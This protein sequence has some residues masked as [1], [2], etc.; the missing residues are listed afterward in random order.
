MTTNIEQSLITQNTGS[1]IIY[2]F[3][4]LG[5]KPTIE[6]WIREAEII[7]NNNALIN[8]T[9]LD[10]LSTPNVTAT[11]NSSTYVYSLYSLYCH[12][13]PARHDTCYGYLEILLPNTYNFVKVTFNQYSHLE[14]S[15]DTTIKLIENKTEKLNSKKK[16]ST[17]EPK[18]VNGTNCYSDGTIFKC[19]YEQE[20]SIPNTILRI[21]EYYNTIGYN[22]KIELSN[23]PINCIGGPT[24]S[25]TSYSTWTN[26]SNPCPN[27]NDYNSIDT[28]FNNITQSRTR[29]YIKTKNQLNGG[30]CNQEADI[31]TKDTRTISCPRNCLGGPVSSD[32]S[33]SVWSNWSDP[34][35]NVN[36][37]NSIDASFN[38]ITQSRTRTYIKTK[39]QLNGGLCNQEEDI[40]TK[41]T[42]TISCPRNCSW[43]ISPWSQCIANCNGINPTSQGIKTR[44]VTKISYAINGGICNTPSNSEPCIKT[45]CVVKSYNTIANDVCTGD[46]IICKFTTIGKHIFIVEQDSFY[47]ILLVGGGGGGGAGFGS[48]GGGGDVIEKLNHRLNKGEYTITI[49]YGGNG[50][51]YTYI[52]PNQIYTSGSNGS[53]SS[54]TSNVTGFIPLYAAGGG[55][56]LTLE[57]K[58]PNITPTEG[59][60]ETNNYSSGGGG[61]GSL[62]ERGGSGNGV[63]GNG[64]GDGSGT[65]PS[66]AGGGGG[67]I[68]SGISWRGQRFAIN[69]GT[70]QIS[71]ITGSPIGYGG[72]GGGGEL[73]RTGIDGGGNGGGNGTA[74]DTNKG[75][76]GGGGGDRSSGGAG[77]SGIVIIKP[78][79]TNCIW[80]AKCIAT[81]DGIS[82]SS[83]GNITFIK[84]IEA[85]N[86][87]ICNAHPNS[88][89][90]TKT[91]CA[92]DC[93]G[94][95]SDWID[96]S[97]NPVCPSRT[98][99]SISDNSFNIIKNRTRRFDISYNELNGG[100]CSQRD[101]STNTS[102]TY[103]LNCPRDCSG[104]YSDWVDTSNNPVC[105]SST[106]YS[107][108]ENS[109]N[110]I[111]NRTRTFNIYYNALNG[112]TCPQTNILN[113]TGIYNFKCA[114][115]CS[116][117]YSDWVDT[118]NNQDC[119]SS[120]NYSISDNSF[121]IIRNRTRRFDILYNELNG[122]ICSQRDIS[123]NTSGTYDLNCPRD[124]LG[125]PVSSDTSYTGWSNWSNPCPNAN[126]Y[127]APDTSFNIIQSRKRTYIKTKNQLN[128]GSCKQ[129]EDI[130][131]KDT[132][133]I[134]CLRNCGGGPTTSDTSYTEWSNWSNPCPNANDYNAPDTSFNI[135]QSRTRTYIKIK[136]QLN[137]G[138]CNQEEDIYTKDKRTITC[139]RDCSG[140]WTDWGD[141]NAN[142]N[143][144]YRTYTIIK[145]HKNNGVP[146]P[147]QL[148]ES[149]KCETKNILS[150]IVNFFKLIL[151]FIL[152]LFKK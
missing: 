146:C 95:Y 98:N 1:T 8:G 23:I 135:T 69:G 147:S 108:S 62:Y 32:A 38:N 18:G 17:I 75:G 41:D 45:N 131:T 20:Y 101:I 3:G 4:L 56:G 76:G 35:P 49:G 124:C 10:I 33:Y 150:V 137:G 31:Y 125:G 86:G 112:G 52:H 128:G 138:S 22:I 27:V 114:R 24:T 140:N 127:N 113:T 77:G 89:P 84:T 151:S 53:T 132:R 149:K 115:D 72:G 68:G 26:W 37:Y 122:G 96:T 83:I 60:I 54:I 79:P 133:T 88:T 152:N 129:E 34:C 116:G 90:C 55:G 93:S 70:G 80:E 63:S 81:C 13:I 105:P 42:R 97:N 111:K 44:N 82:T 118:S 71:S 66:A 15:S 28:S 106:N 2:D 104:N 67:A 94:N 117:N 47:D 50:G 6:Q 11:F 119:P 12:H 92:V 100:I 87:G 36:D 99:Y 107:I 46:P 14:A 43:N 65:Y 25:D 30:L 110:I 74:G 29:T 61:G 64:S 39:N 85:T 57:T 102:G 143:M 123:T 120:T 5:N 130:Y 91:D 121:N 78:I 51:T 9:T 139:P 58:K 145:Q 148:L 134:T 142:T 59:S 126:D 19:L 73:L 109:F 144:H 40:Y 136:N 16:Y 103:D 7:N 21:E 48:G 141:C